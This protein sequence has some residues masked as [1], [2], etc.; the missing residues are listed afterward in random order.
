[1]TSSSERHVAKYSKAL[2][3]ITHGAVKAVKSN[4][5]DPSPKL[6]ASFK[7]LD[8]VVRN[9]KKAARQAVREK[10]ERDKSTAPRSTR[11]KAVGAKAVRAKAS[12]PRT[13]AAGAKRARPT[14]ADSDDDCILDSD[15][16][17]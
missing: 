15:D 10:K 6:R 13:K 9:F 5:K 14:P 11:P 8:N 1:M 12:K 16:C 17:A 3:K 7:D 2:E 4:T